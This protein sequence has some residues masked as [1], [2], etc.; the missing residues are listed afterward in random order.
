MAIGGDLSRAIGPER[1]YL[2][3]PVAK[4][5]AKKAIGRVFDGAELVGKAA[6]GE[7]G[8]PNGGGIERPDLPD[9]PH[10][11][12][13]YTR[14]VGHQGHHLSLHGNSVSVDFLVKRVA[15]NN[16]V[17]IA[18]GSTWLCCTLVIPKVKVVKKKKSGPVEDQFTRGLVAGSK[19][20]HSGKDS[21]ESLHD[22]AIPL[23]V[24]EEVKTV[25]HLG[26]SAKS[27]NPAALA[28]GKG[29]NPDGDQAVLSIR[30]G[31]FV[32]HLPQW[33]LGILC[34]F[35]VYLSG[36]PGLGVAVRPTQSA[37]SSMAFVGSAA[38][39]GSGYARSNSRPRKR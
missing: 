13:Q 21:L 17:L 37:S 33:R 26:G 27:H 34:L 1:F 35:G 20:R 14:R 6:W 36:A 38:V 30:D 10:V 4:L 18:G 15:E 24:F 8:D 5:T 29:R 16:D 19:K 39:P 9:Q 32:M 28:E 22:A 3:K 25:E 2:P 7:Q 12:V 31:R 23:A 11:K